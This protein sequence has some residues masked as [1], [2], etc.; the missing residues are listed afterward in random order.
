MKLTNARRYDYTQTFEV[1]VGPPEDQQRFTVHRDIIC[2]RS[3]FFQAARSERWTSDPGKPTELTDTT[4]S[5]FQDYLYCMYADKDV[6]MSAREDYAGCIQLCLLAGKL[7]GLK[8]ATLAVDEIIRHSDQT[9]T[10]PNLQDIAYVYN[11]TPPGHKLRQLMRDFP[12]HSAGV[13]TADVPDIGCE[14]MSEALY[15]I[16]AEFTRLS[17]HDKYANVEN[18]FHQGSETKPKCHYHQHDAVYPGCES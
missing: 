5:A 9:R 12:I 13:S 17:V 1:I 18:V 15:D 16:C 6:P 7:Q 11:H 14:G 3:K 8:I 4:P 10:C 2:R